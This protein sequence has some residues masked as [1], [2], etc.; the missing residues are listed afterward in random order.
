MFA[1]FMHFEHFQIKIPKPNEFKS[2]EWQKKNFAVTFE[3]CEI[4]QRKLHFQLEF[5]QKNVENGENQ[6]FFYSIK[7]VDFTK[8][9][10]FP[11]LIL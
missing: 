7:L 11:S 3:G 10:H 6:L 9:G 8:N 5:H 1:D 2:F 4:N